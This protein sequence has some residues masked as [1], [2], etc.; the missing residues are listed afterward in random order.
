LDYS[1]RYERILKK[2]LKGVWRGQRNSRLD[3]GGDP[4]CVQYPGS[5][6]RIMIRF[7]EFF[8]GFLFTVAIPIDSQ[9]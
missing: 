5:W 1:K 8:K 2:F 7:H 9:E 3:I 6:I 4:D